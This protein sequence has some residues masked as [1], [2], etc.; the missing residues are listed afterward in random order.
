VRRREGK[1]GLIPSSW[2]DLFAGVR[3]SRQASKQGRSKI[4]EFV[5][6]QS[7]SMKDLLLEKDSVVEHSRTHLQ[8]QARAGSARARQQRSNSKRPRRGWDEETTEEEG[9]EEYVEDDS[10][11]GKR[12]ARLGVGWVVPRL[13]PLMQAC[14]H[15][16]CAP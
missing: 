14:L 13:S 10:T 16:T 4:Q 11:P 15:G 3:P 8:P 6:A 12:V 5:K 9:E 7:M 2:S 1:K